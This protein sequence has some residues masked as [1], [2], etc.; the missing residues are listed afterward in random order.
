M[1][2]EFMINSCEDIELVVEDQ[3]RGAGGPLVDGHDEIGHGRASFE[4]F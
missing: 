4:G 1:L 3:D 2:G